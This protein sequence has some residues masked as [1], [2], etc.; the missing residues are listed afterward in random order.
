MVE[1]EEETFLEGWEL[2]NPDQSLFKTEVIKIHGDCKN[3]P[4]VKKCDVP[5]ESIRKL[6]PKDGYLEKLAIETNEE[7]DEIS[8]YALIKKEKI[9]LIELRIPKDQW[10][11]ATIISE[12]NLP[13]HVQAALNER[14]KGKGKSARFM[15]I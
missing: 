8:Y 9:E 12:N 3:C 10:A 4:Y 7:G 5:C 11:T 13:P 14:R 15:R 1:K 6:V 2:G